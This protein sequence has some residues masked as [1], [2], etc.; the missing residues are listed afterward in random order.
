S[1]RLLVSRRLPAR[2]HE[3][4][5]AE[6]DR[7]TRLSRPELRC[8]RSARRR[9]QRVVPRGTRR[10]H[11]RGCCRNH[12]TCG[13]RSS[14]RY[15][16]DGPRTAPDAIS[17]AATSNTHVFAPALDVTAAGAPDSLKGIPFIGAG[18]S[19]APVTWGSVDQLL[20]DVGSIVGTDGN[21]VERH[22]CGP[23]GALDTPKGTLPTAS[24]SGAIA[25]VQRG[26]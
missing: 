14:D 18:G 23:P 5:D 3:V 19:K 2:R 17:V 4:D 8:R 1:R 20:V 25:L 7:R 16:P 12:R 13:R 26:L 10:G 11:R 9:P 22:L 6:G 21:P 24:L 15:G